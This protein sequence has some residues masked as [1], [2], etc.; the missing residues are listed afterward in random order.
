MNS[1]GVYFA[2]FSPA[3]IPSV[4]PPAISAIVGQTASFSCTVV[5][6]PTPEITWLKGTNQIVPGINPR[7]TISGSSITITDIVVQDG[8]YYT[9]RTTLSSLVTTARA[10]LHVQGKYHTTSLSNYFLFFC[11]FFPQ[12][13]HHLCLRASTSLQLFPTLSVSPAPLY[14]IQA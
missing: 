9:C 1:N 14:L 13:L 11:R 3:G 8:D 4:S 7:I 6:A 12:P 2:L 10:I 5:G